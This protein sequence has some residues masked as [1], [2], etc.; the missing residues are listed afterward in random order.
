VP[1]LN[2]V[3]SPT[4]DE[5][6][7]AR[8]RLQAMADALERGDAATR[9]GELMIDYTHVRSSRE[10]LDRARAIGLDVGEVPEVAVLS[11]DEEHAQP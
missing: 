5:I 1:I 8:D 10:L 3:F 2:E 9:L 11:F 4:E 6:R 7:E